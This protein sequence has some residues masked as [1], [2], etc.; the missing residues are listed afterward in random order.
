MPYWYWN[1]HITEADTDR[2]IR[3]MISQGVHQCIVFPWDGLTQRYLSKE[4]WQQVGAALRIARQLHFTL[5]FADEYDWPSGHAWT[6]PFDAPDLSQ[7][8]R[9]HPEFRMHRL[10]AS[11]ERVEGPRLWHPASD[12]AFA[13]AGRLTPSGAL[14]DDSLTTVPGTGWL[15]PSGH[16]LITTYRLIPSVAAH[17]TRVDLMNPAAVRSYLDLVYEPF[18]RQFSSY[19]G[20]TLKLTVADHE[21]SY[22][23]PIAYTPGLWKA[24]EARHH[25]DL[26]TRLPL[27]ANDTLD[28]QAS[29]RVRADYLDTISQLYADSFSRQVADWCTA[30]RLTH[31]TSIY[32][33]Q[34]YIQVSHAGDMFRH[35]RAGSLVEIDA[36]LERA[37]MPIDFKEALSVAHFDHKPLLVE[38]QGLQGH[39]TFFS[40][41]KAR[42]GSNMALLWGANTLVPYF[43]YDQSKV[44]WPPQWFLSQPFWRYFHLYADYARRAQFMN[45][46]GSHVAPILIYY[47][48]ETAFADSKTI[49]RETPHRDLFWDNAM[50]QTE[51]FFWALQ[52][53][54]ARRHWDYHIV[55]REYLGQTEIR[56][57]ELHLGE[58]AFRVV[59]VPPMTDMDPRSEEKLNQ[60]EQNGG[61]VLRLGKDIPVRQHKP[62]MDH[63]DYTEQIQ[64]PA[65][66]Q[67]DLKPLF[68]ALEKKSP[69]QVEVLDN[70][71]HLFF[72][73]RK[74]PGV[75]WY[76]FVNDTP[77][78]RTVRVRF[79]ATGAFEQWNAE[80]GAKRP[81][82]ESSG[83]V[84][85]TFGPWDAY[86]VVRRDGEQNTASPS[87]NG[88]SIT[89]ELPDTGWRLTLET[90]CVR[91]PYARNEAGKEVWLSPEALSNRKWW[92]IGPFPYDD[93]RGFFQPYGP[94]QAFDPKAHYRG[95]FGDVSWKWYESQD[96][97]LT[98]RDALGLRNQQAVGVFYAYANVYSP[99]EREGRIVTAFADSLA[100]WWN[101][102]KVM[103]VHRHP[104]WS[105]LRDP[106]AEHAAIHLHRGWNRVLLKIGPSLM[107]QTAFSFR[108]AG[109]DGATMRDLVYAPDQQHPP[110]SADAG[111]LSIAIP[112]G[113]TAR[114]AHDGWLALPPR[115]EPEHAV[116][117]PTHPSP[118]R[119]QSWTDSALAN[120]S[121]TALYETTFETRPPA[122][123]KKLF[124]DLGAV[125]VAAE[126]WVN[127]R[128]VGQRAWGPFRFDITQAVHAGTNSL[129]VRV[130]NSDAGW[131]S[132]GDTIYAK[133]SWG[134]HYQTER[135]RLPTIRPN[136]LEGPVRILSGN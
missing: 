84:S 49:F 33:E 35:W 134:L 34:L 104:K 66:I 71:D 52:L 15:V 43:D 79:P 68:I 36:L 111:K 13:V 115:Q 5:N 12:A 92:L 28:G 51:N 21:G 112:P 120:Y 42:L 23:A 119:L 8:L 124:L 7:V 110:E 95:A 97:V 46:Q 90:P 26:R 127:G 102:G 105:L 85:L 22:G 38:N 74:L 24:F 103:S 109:T 118:F 87:S 133:G 91:V 30:H 39:S 45:A 27:L 76:W 32:E 44:T 101:G 16:W 60:F 122:P 130:A 125:G 4:Y 59:I 56:N 55:D 78:V 6:P 25:Y 94:E 58:E 17:G 40:L 3:A 37:R 73:H 132:Q 98:L 69:P 62:F 18:W 11:E 89:K 126:V 117:V 96:Y 1:G 50:D 41:E 19:F 113:T 77:Q 114:G 83:A 72:S 75:D 20:N 100:A 107:V 64:V 136:G 123:G 93:H 99:S 31:G 81:L 88:P 10:A 29:R 48:L 9:Q 86:F 53:E 61:L 108:I 128:S 82:P 131:Q 54:L 121:G 116:C 106:W 135:D 129:R 70:G 14:F 67:H 63:L 47:P 65:D 80:T 57:Q 2:E